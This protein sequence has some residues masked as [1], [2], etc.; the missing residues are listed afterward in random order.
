MA[1]TVGL[2][3]NRTSSLPF[4]INWIKD[5]RYFYS[6][7]QLKYFFDVG[8]NIGQTATD[9][10]EQYG[11]AII[12]SFEPVPATFKQLQAKTA[13]WQ[14]IHIHNTAMSNSKGMASITANPLSGQNTLELSR[15]GDA[16]NQITIQTNT[17]DN[18]CNEHSLQRIDCLKIDTEGHELEVLE[19]A[20]SLLEQGNI[21]LILLECDFHSREN[22]PHGDFI[23]LFECL[24]TFGYRVVS[25]YT[26]GVDDLGWVWGNVLLTHITDQKPGRVACSPF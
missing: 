1:S 2:S 5:I 22:E 4:G 25:F 24:K 12:H 6:E 17:I 3:I 8:A 21:R 15:K 16:S 19:G 20:K 7:Q 18:F 14:Q 26:G 23:S 11:D 9:I 13:K 10:A